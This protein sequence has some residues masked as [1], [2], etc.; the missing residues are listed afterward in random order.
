MQHRDLHSHLYDLCK[1]VGVQLR[2][3]FE[4]KQVRNDKDTNPVVISEGGEHVVGDI[5]RVILVSNQF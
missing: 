3:H 2:H 4:V 5:V 1:K